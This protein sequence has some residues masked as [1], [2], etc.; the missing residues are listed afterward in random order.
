MFPGADADPADAAYV[1]V[2]APLD[3]SASFEPGARFGPRQVRHFAEPFDDYD[4]RTGATFSSLAVAD[5]GDVDPTDDVAEYLQYLA[6]LLGEYAEAGTVPLLL[7]GEH[8]VSVGGLRA[9]EPDVYV[10]CDAHLD[11]YERYAGNPLS[12]ATVTTHALEH[13]D[14][15]VVLGARTGSE[16]EWDRAAEDDVVVVPPAEVADWSPEFGD[17]AAY[18]SI[19][20][21]AL[22]PG[23]APAT[24]TREPFGLAPREVRDVVRSVAPHAVGA[25]VV[26]ITDADQGQTAALGGKLLREFVY[27]R[28]A[29][30]GA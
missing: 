17:E 5:H 24:G 27:A 8:T 13:A 22:D 25:D 19:D 10:C 11:L 7:G 20:V 18:L 1:L 2:G 14:R 21:D 9:T 28:E 4:E 16:R 12:H 30:G 6:G 15:A 3:A 26:E 29:S 23:F